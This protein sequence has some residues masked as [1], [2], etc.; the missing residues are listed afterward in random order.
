VVPEPIDD[1]THVQDGG[2][3][4]LKAFYEDPEKWAYAF[5][6]GAGAAAI[7]CRTLMVLVPPLRQMYVFCTRVRSA[8]ESE[9]LGQ[10][11]KPLRLLE[12]SVFSDR[13]VFVK[14]SHKAKHFSD[15]QLDMYHSTSRC[16]LERYPHVAPEFA[17]VFAAR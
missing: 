1:W 3:N 9:N 6:V 12:R 5:Q 10:A 16:I 11:A 7:G 17:R 4:I 14:N 15:M 8:M 13:N 2:H